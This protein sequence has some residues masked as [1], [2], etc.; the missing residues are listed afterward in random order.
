MRSYEASLPRPDRTSPTEG[1]MD[2]KCNRRGQRS[3]GIV[4]D[5]HAANPPTGMAVGSCLFS[6]LTVFPVQR[7]GMVSSSVFNF[8]GHIGTSTMLARMCHGAP[9]PKLRTLDGACKAFA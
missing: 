7:P 2:A 4:A 9:A 3:R 6:G 8:V 5:S 1:N